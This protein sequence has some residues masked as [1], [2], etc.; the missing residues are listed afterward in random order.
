MGAAMTWVPA[1]ADLI[2]F[3][4][5]VYQVEQP[6][7]VWI[8][9]LMQAAAPFNRGAGI[10]GVLYDVSSGNRMRT[11]FLGGIGLPAGWL[12]AGRAMHHN[13]AVTTHMIAGYR[14][15]I[16]TTFS[17]QMTG[18]NVVETV[19]DA[20][21]QQYGDHGIRGH[22]AVNG[23]DCSGIGC[24]V[25]LFAHKRLT[26]SAS[27]RGLLRQVATHL[28]TAYRLQRRLQQPRSP[29]W[30]RVEA[31]IKPSG[32]IEDAEG[33][34]RS[35]DSRQMLGRAVREREHARSRR[36]G[37][38]RDVSYGW[39]G[40]VAARWT[41][42]DCYER[43]GHRYILARENAPKPNGPDRLSP[44]EQQVCALA[45]LGRSNKLIA[46]ELGLAHSTV[47]VLLTRVYAKFGVTTR[48]ELI[49]RLQTVQR[50][51]DY[52]L[53]HAGLHRPL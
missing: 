20:Y 19:R 7:D 22:I 34:A 32:R 8:L 39:R 30:A 11:D 51:L 31:V 24:C 27:T 23:I 15:Q 16:C 2:A 28:A 6:R 13:P 36:A 50:P 21:D 40:L 17:E 45:T 49:G 14:T 53:D 35:V 41:L 25:Y 9:N 10:G 48:P 5:A 46:Y 52:R 38:A 18:P 4:E 12:E 47:R 26:M 33:E 43:T 42:V 37:E 1:A 3:L 44:R 29:A